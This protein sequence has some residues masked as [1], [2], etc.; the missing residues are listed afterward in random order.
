MRKSSPTVCRD[1]RENLN[2]LLA[3]QRV[4]GQTG[5]NFVHRR[6]SSKMALTLPDLDARLGDTNLLAVGAKTCWLFDGVSL[7]PEDALCCGRWKRDQRVHTKLMALPLIA[8]E[9]NRPISGE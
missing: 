2:K 3:K 9:A 4:S 6:V 5:R 8:V 1:S 7:P